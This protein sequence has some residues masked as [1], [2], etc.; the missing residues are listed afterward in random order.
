MMSGFNSF[1][2]DIIKSLRTQLKSSENDGVVPSDV[3]AVDA[4]KGDVPHFNN[5]DSKNLEF[6][7]STVF[8]LQEQ[9]LS[10]WLKIDVVDGLAL[11][12]LNR[13]DSDSNWVFGRDVGDDN[14]KLKFTRYYTKTDTAVGSVVGEFAVSVDTWIHCAFTFSGDGVSKDYINGSPVNVNA[15]PVDFEDWNVATQKVV[16]AFQ[17][18]LKD[19]RVYDRVLSDVEVTS[20][21]NGEVLSS[22]LVGWWKLDEGEGTVA[23]DS[24]QRSFDVHLVG[25]EW[26]ETEDTDVVLIDSDDSPIEPVAM[27]KDFW[28]DIRVSL[29]L[30]KATVSPQ[31]WFSEC[32]ESV[33]TLIDKVLS[34]RSLGG[35]VADV[36]PTSHRLG[37]V[38][39]LNRSF[40]GGVVNL[41]LKSFYQ[42]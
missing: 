10:F 36:Y 1:Y 7:A 14:G 16:S 21:F 25:E 12:V 19:I 9:T 23:F 42:P 27:D 40:Y 3:W 24:S 20:V 41:V 30:L 18:Y 6:P 34:D 22:G 28:V 35:L 37:Q 5:L 13:L 26:S 32:S 8:D 29:L 38:N 39:L 31:N 11:S 2:S 15:V 33:G 4:E 17:G